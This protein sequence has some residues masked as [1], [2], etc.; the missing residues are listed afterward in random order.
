MPHDDSYYLHRAPVGRALIHLA[1]PMMAATTVGVVYNVVNAGFV[2]SLNSTALLAALAFGLP[3]TSLLMAIAGV[4]GTGGSSAIS[5]LLGQLQEA[6]EAGAAALRT[7]VRRLSAFTVWGSV[8]A[9]AVVGALGLAFLHP[10]TRL[11]GAS[12]EA[13][14]PTAGY[15]GAML[16]GAPVLVLAFAIEQLVRAEGA[17][18]A[19]MIGIVASTVANL[20]LDVLFILVLRWGVTG[21]ALA[22]VGSNAVAVAYFVRYLHRHSPQLTL[23]PRWLR[24]DRRMAAEVFGVGSSELLMMGFLTLTAVV[25]NHVAA[26]YGEGV[27]AAFG[28]AQRVVQV[29]EMLAMG[30]H[31]GAMPLLATA[32]GAGATTRLRAGL[33]HSAAWTAVIVA[34][35]ALP[36]LLLRERL[37]T[38]FSADP[39]VLSTGLAVLVALLV[40]TL[41]NGF[42]GLATTLFQATGQ[43]GPANLMGSA[44]GVLF[45]PVVLVANALFGLTGLIWAMTVTEMLCFGL[46]VVLVRSRRRHTF[47]AVDDDGVES[48][49]AA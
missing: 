5:R 48:L 32:F 37:L 20:V 25:F 28:V 35:F 30:V 4:F 34:V 6:D 43:A 17:T 36:V 47:A 49:V 2:G 31:L 41:V 44:Q 11:L 46:A 27:L 7:R 42:T 26:R 39:T 3:M 33:T 9:G 24:P 21:A 18:R 14:A 29:P 38:L 10:L 16:A 23:S 22:L 1:V 8:L 45:V 19:S 40:S 15:V 13:F 12:G